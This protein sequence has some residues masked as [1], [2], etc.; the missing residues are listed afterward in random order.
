MI[1]LIISYGIIDAFKL[2][3]RARL[4]LLIE[5]RLKTVQQIMT[6]F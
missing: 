5:S 1:S 4:P 2:N 6:K 3:T